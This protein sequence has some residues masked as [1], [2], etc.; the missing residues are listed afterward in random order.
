MIRTKHAKS[1][2]IAM[3]AK[4]QQKADMDLIP[5][6]LFFIALSL[7]VVSKCAHFLIVFSD[8]IVA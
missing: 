7:S 4:G 8:M 6:R 1:V 5:Y 3:G 2:R